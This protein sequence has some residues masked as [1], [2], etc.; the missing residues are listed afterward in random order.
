[1]TKKGMVL[2]ALVMFVSFVIL[3]A[4]VT[5][6]QAMDFREHTVSGHMSEIIL[7]NTFPNN[8]CYVK[9]DNGEYLVINTN[10]FY[11]YTILSQVNP[12]SNVT[13]TYE[14]NSNMVTRVTEIEVD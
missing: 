9:F 2:F 7:Y 4:S 8:E 5:L 6:Y 11:A 14:R 10:Y 1:M 12:N 13:I 3:G